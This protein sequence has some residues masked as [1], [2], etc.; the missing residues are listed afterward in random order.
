MVM[1]GK[2]GRG[3]IWSTPFVISAV[4]LLGTAIS[5]QVV[6]AKMRISLTKEA[7]PLQNPLTRL[8]RS[9]MWPYEFRHAG[10][11]DESVINELG[12]REYIA[13]DFVD[14]RRKSKSDPERRVHF[15]VTYY[16]GD[17]D[18]VPHT[19]DVCLLGSGYTTTKKE[20][21]EFEMDTRLG[22]MT[23]PLRVLD[24]EK[25]GIHNKEK[26]T[27]AYLFGTNGKLTAR[28]QGVRFAINDPRDR[29]AYYS[30]V[31]IRFG[32]PFPPR[33]QMIEATK[34]FLKVALPVLI[35]D[36]WPDWDAVK[37]AESEGVVAVSGK[38]E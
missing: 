14:T 36:H 18:S 9:K 24:S 4:L 5:L 13:W 30:K 28:R 20:N 38:S 6:V 26:F 17:P 3:G 32:P 29:H 34:R 8:D 27:V 22:P 1:A 12:T 33:E 23:V 2:G 31:E 16:T 15:F 25:S 11:L 37:A 35:E 19:P 21:I 7:V 10:D